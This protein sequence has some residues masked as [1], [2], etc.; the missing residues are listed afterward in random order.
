MPS[1]HKKMRNKIYSLVNRMKY[2][3][4]V[5]YFDL[6]NKLKYGRDAPLFMETLW[7]N[8]G[9]VDT[10]I[11]KEEVFNATGLHRSNVSGMIVDWDDVEKPSSLADEYRIQ[12]C[13]K[14]WKENESWDE[15]G[16]ID[17]MTKS[18]K[19]GDWPVEKIRARFQ[20]LDKAFEE[21]K[22]LGRLKKRKE[23]DP[24]NFREKD[25]IYVHIAKNGKPVFGGNGFHR[26]AISKVLGLEEIPVCVG[27]VDKEAIPLL[28]NYRK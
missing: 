9:D 20:M 4:S 1:F 5:L 12:Y 27:M 11:G 25:G 23:I 8:P 2:R 15:I 7:V 6:S 24:D 3:T 26:L 18:N 22:K 14:H 19:Y 13:Y 17:Y 28:K 16:V 21:T 10:V